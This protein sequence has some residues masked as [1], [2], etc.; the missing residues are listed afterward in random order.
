LV[1]LHGF[2]GGVGIWIKNYDSLSE[3]YRVYALDVPGF[4]R[5]CQVHDDSELQANFTI[6]RIRNFFVEGLEQ[7]RAAT[8]L[9][10]PFELL[11]HSL[12]GYIAAHY[13]MRYPQ[14][15]RHLHLA[16]PFGFKTRPQGTDW[17]PRHLKWHMRLLAYVA[18]Y[19]GPMAMVRLAGPLG[20]HLVGIRSRYDRSRYDFDD[21]RVVHYVYHLVAMCKGADKAFLMLNDGIGFVREPLMDRFVEQFSRASQPLPLTLIYGQQD[22]IIAF[23][24]G[25]MLHQLLPHSRLFIIPDAAHHSYATHPHDFHKAVAHHLT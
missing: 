9:T 23:D 6:E 19:V 10:E 8:G 1:L 21:D 20:P 24:T 11:G 15:V 12:G 13:A 2:G 7:W 4:G 18:L 16:S 3:H 17:M 22:R 25:Q 14:H 5:S